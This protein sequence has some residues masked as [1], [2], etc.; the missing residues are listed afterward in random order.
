MW[1]LE[2]FSAILLASTT[3]SGPKSVQDLSNEFRKLYDVLGESAPVYVQATPTI[4]FNFVTPPEQGQSWR[5]DEVFYADQDLVTNDTSSVPGDLFLDVAS[6]YGDDKPIALYLPG[7]DGFGVSA[8][9]H[10]FDDLSRSFELWRMSIKIEDRTSFGD[11]LKTVTD[12][13]E[14]LASTTERPIYVIAESFGGLLAPSVGLKLQKK[15]ERNG[16]SNPLRGLVLVNPAT[17]FDESSWDSLAPLLTLFG[18]LTDRNQMPFNL[19]SPYSIAGGLILSSLIPSSEQNQRILQTILGLE[20]LRNPAGAADSFQGM[21]NSFRIT[22]DVLPP[23]LLKHR[24]TNWMIVG[25]SLIN[26]RLSQLEVNTLVVV[27]TEDKLIASG[28]EVR[29][30]TRTLPNCEKLEVKGA[31]HFVLDDNVNLTEAIVYSKLLD[32]LNFNETQKP[33]DP[34]IDWKMPS[35]EV[36]ERI[37]KGSVK[38]L[39]DAFSPVFISTDDDGNRSFGLQ[40]LPKEGPLLFVAN[41]QLL[42]LDLNLLMGEF[43]DN[44]LEVRGLAHPVIFQGPNRQRLELEGRVPGLKNPQPPAAGPSTGNFELFGA[45]MVTPRNYYRL[46]QTAQN[47]LLFPGG[48]KEVFHSR[49]QAYQ[50][51]W[52]EKTDFVRTAAR[53]NAT[54]VPLS[55]I[56]MADSLNIILD[57]GEVASLPFLGERARQFAKNVTAAR[58]DVANEEENFLPP[59]VAPGLPSR[60]YFLFGKPLRTTDLDPKDKVACNS[61][62]MDVQMEMKRG[63]D[64][65]LAAREKDPYKGA[66]AR[67]AYEQLIG[68]KAP[69][70][71]IEDLDEATASMSRRHV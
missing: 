29:R 55:A 14:Q 40:N 68:S 62:Y 47:V 49:E 69:T 61:L 33:Y 1:G 66:P 11:L 42:G 63:F 70:F 67:I 3:P 57:S 56:G 35:Q 59:I 31:G 6:R 48:V 25:S 39:S 64:V 17:S 36:V 10:Q 26:P 13:V 37:R 58:F 20:T 2:R 5:D 19:P 46:L 21:L 15:Y 71:S 65:V 44:G 24:I 50:L 8:A 34:I 32:P 45:V 54:I 7:L 38:S 12:F 60:N 43:I 41:H 22:A 16:K 28:K 52:P 53:F 30:L 9:I 27:G 18:D 23:G 51:L 4:R